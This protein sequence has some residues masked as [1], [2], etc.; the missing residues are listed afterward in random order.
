MTVTYDECV[1]V[2]NFDEIKHKFSSCSSL[3]M[4]RI[5]F[6]IEMVFVGTA[7]DVKNDG[8]DGENLS[9]D[10]FLFFSQADCFL[11]NS[12]L[13]ILIMIISR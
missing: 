1:V 9:V 6:I 7:D 8:Q 4:V 13:L 12:L 10:A 11:S 5:G 3:L 2:E